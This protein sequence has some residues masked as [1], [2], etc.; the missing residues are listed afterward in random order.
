MAALQPT[1]GRAL[2][3][4]G[5]DGTRRGTCESNR[6]GMYGAD[7]SLARRCTWPRYRT[8]QE[9]NSREN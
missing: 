7:Q 2:Q 4:R 8:D 9:D 1:R 3:L 6:H 5:V